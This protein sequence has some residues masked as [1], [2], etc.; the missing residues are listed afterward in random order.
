MSSQEYLTPKEQD[1]LGR[2]RSFY[3]PRTFLYFY[4]LEVSTM[5]PNSGLEVTIAT[6]RVVMLSYHFGNSKAAGLLLMTF[7]LQALE[8]LSFGLTSTPEVCYLTQLSV[9]L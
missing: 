2:V 8:V 1:S 3:L 9:G 7:E 4:I 5:Y 6:C